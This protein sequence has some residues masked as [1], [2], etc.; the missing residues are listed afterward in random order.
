MRPRWKRR[1][2]RWRTLQSVRQKHK[3]ASHHCYAYVIGRNAG[4]M[5][6]SD[7]GEPGGTAGLPMMEVLKARGVVNCCASSRRYFGGVLL[8]AGGLVRAY[9]QGAAIAL[10][11]RRWSPWSRRSATFAR[12]PIRCGIALRHAL[13]ALPV[14]LVSIEFTTAVTFSLLVRERDA[15]ALLAELTRLTDGRAEALLEEESYQAWNAE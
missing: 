8:G 12:F 14:Q 7:D 6:Y 5:R 1:R 15:D 3:D 11:A 13:N 4:V 2:R 10:N 9:T